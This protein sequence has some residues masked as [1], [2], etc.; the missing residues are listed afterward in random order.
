MVHCTVCPGDVWIPLDTV[1]DH[2]ELEHRD[3]MD[4]K[5]DRYV[6]VNLDDIENTDE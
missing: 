5:A 2:M 4:P 6:V 3:Q 1:L